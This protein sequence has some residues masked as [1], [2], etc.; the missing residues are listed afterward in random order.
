MN[1]MR[2]VLLLACVAALA[3]VPAWAGPGDVERDAQR[4]EGRWHHRSPGLA[5]EIGFQAGRAEQTSWAVQIALAGSDPPLARSWSGWFPGVGE[6]AR[7]R[8]VDLPQSAARATGLPRRLYFGF[9]GDDL[10]IEVGEG[11]LAGRR[12][13]VRDGKPAWPG[14]PWFGPGFLLAYLLSAV[15]AAAAAA[16]A[17]LRRRTRGA[18]GPGAAAGRA[19]TG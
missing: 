18:A 2:L 12:R 5:W 17:L 1:T 10:V 4:L 14:S 7:G 15:V 19:G 8:F 3:A 16:V 13:F 11:P 9:Q 6:D